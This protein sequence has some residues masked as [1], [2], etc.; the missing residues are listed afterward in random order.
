MRA[1]IAVEFMFMIM[2]AFV[3]LVVVLLVVGT[4][5]GSSAEQ[6]RQAAMEDTAGVI[7]QEFLLAATVPDGYRR[8]FTLPNELDGMTYT[9]EV[10]E[11]TLT[12]TLADGG[13]YSRPIPP[14]QGAPQ[15]GENRIQRIDG[16][17]LVDQP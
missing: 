7:Q 12:L 17:I 6:K 11:R 10:L 8:L 14:V 16:E 3:F 15:P 2:L 1:Q 9:I 13:T 4:Y 5:L